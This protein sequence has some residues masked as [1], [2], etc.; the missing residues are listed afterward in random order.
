MIVC[1]SHLTVVQAL[2][3]MC[4]RPLLLPD[5]EHPRSVH[6]DRGPGRHPLSLPQQR[7]VLGVELGQVPGGS[8]QL[9]VVH[10]QH[11][12]QCHDVTVAAVSES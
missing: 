7:R 10:Q 9:S 1:V 5:V 12:A 11:H 4:G 2:T 6:L 8:R 3:W